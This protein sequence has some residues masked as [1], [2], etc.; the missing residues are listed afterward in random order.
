MYDVTKKKVRIHVYEE[1]KHW[2][3]RRPGFHHVWSETYKT[4]TK[5]NSRRGKMQHVLLICYILVLCLCNFHSN[6]NPLVLFVFVT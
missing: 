5:E 2:I 4:P 3:Q 1:T 6:V